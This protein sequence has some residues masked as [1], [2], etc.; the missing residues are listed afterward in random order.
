MDSQN[1]KRK[2]AI[3]FKL[4]NFFFKKSRNEEQH[5]L[6]HD[7]NVPGMIC[8]SEKSEENQNSNEF[9]ACSSISVDSKL[10]KL[11]SSDVCESEDRDP[12]NR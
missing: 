5:D 12:I 3:T 9:L 7:S 11:S 2:S 1:S 10:E 4:S 8:E 6:N